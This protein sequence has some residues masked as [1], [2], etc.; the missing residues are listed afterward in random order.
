[1][2]TSRCTHAQPQH[3]RIYN[4]SE[5]VL[6]K[7]SGSTTGLASG[8]AHRLTTLF[9]SFAVLAATIVLFK[10]IPLGF[11]PNQDTGQIFGITEAAQDISYDAMRA[12]Q[13]QVAAIVAADTNVAGFMSSI[14][15][16]GSTVAGNSG[17]IFMRLKPRSS[18][19]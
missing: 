10:I 6:T 3:S 2:L 19:N 13:M 12:H 7:C 9:V 15:A 4:W 11:F 1:M 14:G 17:R 5:K 8:H 16:G 18:A